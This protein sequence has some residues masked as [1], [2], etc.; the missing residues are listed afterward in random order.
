MNASV[1]SEGEGQHPS[2]AG[3]SL[4]PRETEVLRL[5]AQGFSNRRSPISSLSA[6]IPS[7]P[8]CAISSR[9]QAPR[10]ALKPP[11]GPSP[12]GSPTP[13]TRSTVRRCRVSNHSSGSNGFNRSSGQ[14]IYALFSD[15]AGILRKDVVPADA[16]IGH[17]CLAKDVIGA[18]ASS[19][20]QSCRPRKRSSNCLAVGS[21][22]INHLT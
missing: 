12:T 5:V 15:T 9:R 6:T 3:A 18:I 4:T 10:T 8:T 13:R 7:S 16:S 2:P 11:S 19:V 21:L 20:V 1:P 22:F 17:S 14:T